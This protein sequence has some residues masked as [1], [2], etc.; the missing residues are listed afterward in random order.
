MRPTSEMP[1]FVMANVSHF[2]IGDVDAAAAAVTA[3]PEDH[4]LVTET[5]MKGKCTM[6][7][8]RDKDKWTDAECRATYTIEKLHRADSNSPKHRAEV[9]SLSR[10]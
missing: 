6:F 2:I 9:S 4:K 3:R 10:Q 7:P 5:R 1:L 8:L